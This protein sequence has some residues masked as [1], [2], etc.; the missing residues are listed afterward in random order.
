MV[1]QV[2]NKHNQKPEGEDEIRYHQDIGDEM[3]YPKKE[4]MKASD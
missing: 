3:E 2:Y 4:Q 1:C